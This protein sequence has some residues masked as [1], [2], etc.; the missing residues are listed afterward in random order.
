MIYPFCPCAWITISQSIYR[1]VRAAAAI[2][3]AGLPPTPSPVAPPP[4]ALDDEDADDWGDLMRGEP[5]DAGLLQ[6]ALHGFYPAGTRPCA[7]ASG[8]LL[9]AGGGGRAAVPIKLERHD[10]FIDV[11]EEDEYPMMPP[12][13]LGDV[14]QYPAFVEAF[15]AAPSAPTRRGRRG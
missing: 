8:N 5:A 7:G 14:I 11:D 2:A 3:E 6:D 13:L 15:V 12:G 10:A 1:A 9:A 4:A